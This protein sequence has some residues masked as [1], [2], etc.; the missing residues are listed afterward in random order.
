MISK[1]N[2]F[3]KAC[4]AGNLEMELFFHLLGVVLSWELKSADLGLY[5]V[6][7]ALPSF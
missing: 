2:N 1:H 6:T 4:H 3:S 7:V 5:D